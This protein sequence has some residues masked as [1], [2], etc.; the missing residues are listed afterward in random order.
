VIT[1]QVRGNMDIELLVF[2]EEQ[3]SP[4]LYDLEKIR[5]WKERRHWLVLVCF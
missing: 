1:A 3:W 4:D 2:F 5:F